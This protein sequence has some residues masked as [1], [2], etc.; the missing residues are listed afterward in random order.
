MNKPRP[1][2]LS[3]AQTKKANRFSLMTKQHI[4]QEMSTA[5]SPCPDFLYKYL[6]LESINYLSC[7]LIDS[8]LYLNNRSQ[9]NDPFDSS[10][11]IRIEDSKQKLRKEFEYFIKRGLKETNQIMDEMTVQGL[12]SNQMEKFKNTPFHLKDFMVSN[13]NNIGIYCLT[14]NNKN[15]LMWSHYAS[16]HEGLVLEFD[17]A[18]TIDTFLQTFK[19]NYSK[20]YPTLSFLNK[21]KKEHYVLLTTKSIDWEYEKEWRIIRTNGAFNYLAFNPKALISLTFGCRAS[22]STRNLVSE[23]LKK[24]DQLGLPKIQIKQAFMHESNYELVIE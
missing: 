22:E 12:I 23:M 20:N 6:S 2:K 3:D 17:V 24:R 21:N 7:L 13:I 9:F 16:N 14:E 4:R 5:K 1:P 8:D 19:I 11:Y 18:E 15:I 10:A